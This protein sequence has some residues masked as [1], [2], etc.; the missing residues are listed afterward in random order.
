MP[1]GHKM[2]P[3]LGMLRVMEATHSP[4]VQMNMGMSPIGLEDPMKAQALGM[5]ATVSICSGA[6]MAC[7]TMRRKRLDVVVVVV[8]PTARMKTQMTKQMTRQS[9]AVAKT[10]FGRRKTRTSPQST[11][12]VGT[13]AC[14]MVRRRINNNMQSRMACTMVRRRINNN[15]QSM[16]GVVV[17][18]VVVAAVAVVAAVVVVVVMV[19]M[20]MVVEGMEV[21]G[22]EVE[23]MVV[24]AVVLLLPTVLAWCCRI[25]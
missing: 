12:V 17:V 15:M 21:E 16:V 4:V 5:L 10:A 1:N 8:T 9:S 11:L 23:G 18:V 25:L 7:M 24:A 22:M 2:M 20:G 13:M 19:V 3:T 6:L 14:S